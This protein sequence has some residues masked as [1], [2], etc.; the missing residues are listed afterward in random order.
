[1]PTNRAQRRDLENAPTDRAASLVKRLI[2]GRF[3]PRTAVILG[4]GLGGASQSV[5]PIGEIPFAALEGMPV[6]SALGHPGQLVVGQWHAAGV[7]VFL[8]RAHRYEGRSWDEIAFAVRLARAVGVRDI[9]LTNMSGGIDPK[10]PPGSLALIDGHLDLMG[11]NRPVGG[12]GLVLPVFVEGAYS[13]T[14][15]ALLERSAAARGIRLT[16]A[17]YAGVPGPNYETPAEVRALARMGATV[18][19]MSTI[20]EAEVARELGMDCCCVS[21]VAN[22][23]AG[24]AHGPIRH[25]DVLEGARRATGQTRA[26]LDGFFSLLSEEYT[27]TESVPDA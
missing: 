17:V 14:L 16:R 4:S 26:L 19:G 3:A 7:L 11:W 24:V 15:G 25:E 23:A 12:R 20:G 5:A 2:A 13:R 8:G 21:C 27:P 9:V 1:M 6:P 22:P 18:V 10:L